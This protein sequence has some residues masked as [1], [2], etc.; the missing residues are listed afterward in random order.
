MEGKKSIAVRYT[1]EPK[2]VITIEQINEMMKEIIKSVEEK[3]NGKVR[4]GR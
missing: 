3:T 4:D 1:F 2:D